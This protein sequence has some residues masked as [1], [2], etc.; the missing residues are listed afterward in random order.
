MAQ[1]FPASASRLSINSQ[2]L[3]CTEESKPRKL[4]GLKRLCLAAS[5]HAV[6]PLLRAPVL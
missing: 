2:N 6:D 3:H 4:K 1:E 5:E